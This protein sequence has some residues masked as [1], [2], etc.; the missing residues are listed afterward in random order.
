[1]RVSDLMARDFFVVVVGFFFTFIY[2]FR[3]NLVNNLFDLIALR[4]KWA[5]VIEEQQTEKK[6]EQLK[7]LLF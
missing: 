2:L 1:M 5:N 3:W 6:K 7:V 4:G